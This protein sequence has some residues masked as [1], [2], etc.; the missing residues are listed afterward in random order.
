MK[1]KDLFIKVSNSEYEATINGF[2]LRI[3]RSPY[4]WWSWRVSGITGMNLHSFGAAN[5]KVRAMIVAVEDAAEW[6][7]RVLG[8]KP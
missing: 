2:R 7:K 1:T 6:T 5:R 3:T 4:G 8:K